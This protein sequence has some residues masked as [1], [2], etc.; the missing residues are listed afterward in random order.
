MHLNSSVGQSQ[1]QKNFSSI[2]ETDISGWNEIQIKAES[3]KKSLSINTKIKQRPIYS[4]FK[5]RKSISV[6][7]KYRN[8]A[9]NSRY[10][11]PELYKKSKPRQKSPIY[12]KI[13]LKFHEE[14]FFFIK[15]KSLSQLEKLMSV[16]E[17]RSFASNSVQ[18][19]KLSHPTTRK[20]S[21]SPDKPLKPLK[22]FSNTLIR[23]LNRR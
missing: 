12:K 10:M 3:S 13:P 16:L 23:F 22:I 19:P 15:K 6:E 8:A 1:F 21:K 11:N 2:I 5:P 20:P 18:L 4:F 7:Q 14:N 9:I 17:T